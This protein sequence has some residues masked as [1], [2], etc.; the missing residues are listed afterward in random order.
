MNTVPSI[1]SNRTVW[2][3]AAFHLFIIAIS[4]YLVQIPVTLFGLHTTWGAISFPFIFLATDLTIRIYGAATARKIIFMAMLPALLISYVLS[5][6]F[7]E[8]QFQGTGA[9]SELNTFV[10]RIA[11]ASFV[12]YTLGQLL[13]VTVF[14]KLR[15]TRQ[16]WVAPAAST[17]IG[18]FLD[19]LLFFAIAFYQS[20]DEFM[21]ANWPE[22]AAVDYG[23][24]LLVSLSLFV[25]AYGLLMNTL[26][27]RIEPRA[28]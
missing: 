21:A 22:I 20:T 18:G 26:V 27:K 23:I 2:Y 16:W 15:Q 10:A 5:V 28:V 13:D 7:F 3:L 1:A 24:K 6:L 4:N 25:P 12:A 9:L 17:V 19:T 14:S 8:A 11:L